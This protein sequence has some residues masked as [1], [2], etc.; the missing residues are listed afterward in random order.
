MVIS[1]RL[2]TGVQQKHSV[3]VQ[4]VARWSTLFTTAAQLNKDSYRQGHSLGGKE[5]GGGGLQWLWK[6]DERI[7]IMLGEKPDCLRLAHHTLDG[8]QTSD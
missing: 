8:A 7:E 1:G 3:N 6:R 5:G 4:P 2:S